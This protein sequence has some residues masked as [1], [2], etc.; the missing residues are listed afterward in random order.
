MPASPQGWHQAAS[1]DGGSPAETL[2][3][4]AGAGL[5]ERLGGRGAA[6][7]R[8]SSVSPKSLQRG[9]ARHLRPS[10]SQ[11]APATEGA[12]LPAHLATSRH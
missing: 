3:T 6:G 11:T 5:W 7:Q 8:G 10:E 4:T 12:A 9:A 1:R 2:G